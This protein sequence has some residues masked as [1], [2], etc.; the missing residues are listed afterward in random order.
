MLCAEGSGLRFDVATCKK[1]VFTAQCMA[2]KAGSTF[3]KRIG[4]KQTFSTSTCKPDRGFEKLAG[5]EV[6]LRTLHDVVSGLSFA[7]LNPVALITARRDA[8]PAATRPVADI[9]PA[10]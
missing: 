9:A 1:D 7:P 3:S 5:G 10:A 2:S 8:V 6:S 4:Q